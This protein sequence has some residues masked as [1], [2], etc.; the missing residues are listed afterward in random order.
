[1][2][3]S[4]LAVVA[5]IAGCTQA[6]PTDAKATDLEQSKTPHLKRPKITGYNKIDFDNLTKV[7]NITEDRLSRKANPGD[8]RKP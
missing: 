8:V 5:A 1:M 4:I 6:A 3:I 2:R 7:Y